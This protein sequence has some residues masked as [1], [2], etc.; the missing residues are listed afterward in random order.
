M[1]RHIALPFLR[2]LEHPRQLPPLVVT[3]VRCADCA[4][5]DICAEE[6]TCWVANRALTREDTDGE[7]S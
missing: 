3:E 4:Y 6:S 1:T 7:S 5:P 2:P